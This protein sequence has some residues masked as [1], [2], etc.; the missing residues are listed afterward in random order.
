MR[1]LEPMCLELIS[2]DMIIK[3]C[4][5]H[6]SRYGEGLG[7]SIAEMY[8]VYREHVCFACKWPPMPKNGKFG[9]DREQSLSVMCKLKGTHGSASKGFDEK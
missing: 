6:L 1:C 7:I 5:Y 8:L 3:R 2:T 4:S 9:P